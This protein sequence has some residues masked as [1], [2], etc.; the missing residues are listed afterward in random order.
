MA[1]NNVVPSQQRKFNTKGEFLGFYDPPRYRVDE[2]AIPG[3][4]ATGVMPF[5]F[6]RMRADFGTRFKGCE[7]AVA[8]RK[9]LAAEG[10]YND[11]KGQ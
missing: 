3:L 4:V 9:V 11:E 10:Y 6:L 5:R 8:A 2:P 7:D 1:I